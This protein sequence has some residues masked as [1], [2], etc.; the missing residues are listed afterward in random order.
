MPLPF[1]PENSESLY[2]WVNRFQNRY[3]YRDRGL[4]MN[5]IRQIM[6]YYYAT[7]SFVDYQIGRILEALE[8]TGQLDNTLI[9]F[10]SDHGEHLGDLGCFGKRSMHDPSSKVPMI[11]RY[12]ERFAAGEICTT[13]TSLVDLFPTLLGAADISP[14]ELELDGQDLATIASNPDPD[15]T[16]YSQFS[17]EERAIYMAVN[18]KEKYVYSAGDQAEFF[19][20]RQADPAEVNNLA[21]AGDDGSQSAM[22]QNLL[23]YLA[24]VGATEA[25][26]EDGGTYRWQEYPPIDESYLNDPDAR[27]LFQDYPSYP[28]ELPGYTD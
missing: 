18:E 2:T 26:V 19:F 8:E 20:D 16:V 12:P 22:R 7:I 10:A 1:L 25:Y 17:K 28:T 23:G 3:K 15:R 6:A 11:V 9:I 24:A 27:L 13:A 4:D 5:L 21:A 14:A